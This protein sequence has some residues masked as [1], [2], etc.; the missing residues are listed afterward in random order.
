M[1]AFPKPRKDPNLPTSYRPISLLS[2]LSKVFEIIILNRIK[3]SKCLDVKLKDHQF[4]FRQYKSTVQ[5]L[6]RMI[7]DVSL[8]FNMNK[9][10]SAVLMDIEKAFDTATLICKNSKLNIKNKLLIYK[11]LLRP[12]MTYVCPAWGSM[13]NKTSL[14]TLQKIQNKCLR[15]VLNSTLEFRNCT[16]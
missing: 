7:N 16:S 10:T 3:D 4:G 11:T 14:N 8:Q 12:I 5:Q 2:T 1:L 13:A 15:M 6:L 9:V